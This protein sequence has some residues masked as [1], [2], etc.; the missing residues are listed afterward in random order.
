M[1]GAHGT[2][3]G[4]ALLPPEASRSISNALSHRARGKRA[5]A[6]R[7]DLGVVAQPQHD[8]IGAGRVSELVHRALER[9]MSERLVRRAHG[10]RCVAIYMDDLVV[11]GDAAT[12]S[13]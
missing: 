6:E 4:R 1:A 11:R 8:R 5:A 9:E 10:S 13:P 3:L 12:G 2:R 7:G